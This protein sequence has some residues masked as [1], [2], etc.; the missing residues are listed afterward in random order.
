MKETLPQHPKNAGFTLVELLI[1][2]AVSGI[3]LTAVFAAFKSQQDSYL[4][5]DQVVEMQE[6]IRAGVG[7]MTQELR[8]AGYDPYYTGNI[9]IEAAASSNVAFTLVAD[10]DGADN[11][12]DGSTDETGETKAVVF[13]CYDAYGDGDLDIGMQEV[14]DVGNLAA[15]DEDHLIAEHFQA[16]EFYYLDEEGNPTAVTDDI[17][18]VMI[19]VLARSQQPDGSFNNTRTYTS[20]SGAAWGP[21]DDHFRRRFQI[22]TVHLRNKDI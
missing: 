12:G 11:D 3:L 21:Y 5:Q 14:S 19:S 8:M 10:S 13:N 20:A 18:T 22:V 2:L 6:N 17:E 16:L 7:I 9:G 15:W 1:G 4:A